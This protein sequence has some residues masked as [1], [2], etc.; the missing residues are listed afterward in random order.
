[1]TFELNGRRVRDREEG[2]ADL[3]R[4]RSSPDMVKNEPQNLGRWVV[5][6]DFLGANSDMQPSG[7]DKTEAVISYFKG[8]PE[9]W[10]IG[11][12]TYSG[13]IYKNLWPGLILRITGPMTG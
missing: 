3:R 4:N 5:K 7:V 12:P 9:E 1:L 6:L 11:L 13:I 10:K 8:K 2:E